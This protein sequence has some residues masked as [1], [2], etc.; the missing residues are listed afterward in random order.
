MNTLSIALRTA[1]M[2]LAASGAAAGDDAL[3]QYEV[4]FEAVWSSA[5]HP[6]ANFPFNPH[7]S[8]LVGGTHHDGVSFWTPGGIASPG[9]EQMAESGNRTILRSE[10]QGAIAAGTA[11]AE[12]LGGGPSSP[13]EVSTTFTISQSHPLVSL[14]TMVA[15]SPDWFVGVH[16]LE[17][18]NEDGLWLPE[19][20]VSLDPY[21]AGTDSGTGYNSPNVNTNPEEPIRNIHDEAPFNANGVLGRFVFTRVTDTACS[22]A[23]LAE[24]IGVLDVFDV[25]DYLEAFNAGDGSADLNNDG[26]HDIFDVFAYLDAFNAGCVF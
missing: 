19:L 23:D 11:E 10:V 1:V 5:S 13:G 7:F 26:V 6:T 22:T 8:P 3:V 20:T 21:D 4:R 14:V 24:P 2:G 12:I 9:I 15:P 18:Q 16:A 25:F 17:L